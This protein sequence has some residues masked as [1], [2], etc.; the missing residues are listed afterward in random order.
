MVLVTHEFFSQID[1]LIKYSTRLKH[2]NQNKF[3]NFF[4]LFS[5]FWSLSVSSENHNVLNLKK[6]LEFNVSAMFLEGVNVVSP[7][8]E[9]YSSHGK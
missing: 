6:G 1:S 4:I 9:S 3:I 8:I 5:F 7:H 2:Q